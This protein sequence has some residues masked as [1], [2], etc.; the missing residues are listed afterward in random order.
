MSEPELTEV[1]EQLRNTVGDFF[2][3][4]V[5]PVC[6]EIEQRAD[7]AA[8]MPWDLIRAGS[9]LGLRT[10]A[11]PEEWGGI[12]ADAAIRALL[13]AEMSQIEPGLA[14]CFYSCWRGSQFLYHLATPAQREKFLRPFVEDDT[15]CFSTAFTEPGAGSDNLI[16]SDDPNRG[17]T[18]AATR[19][20]EEW[21][22][23][24]Q[25]QWISLAGFSKCVL[26][27]ARTNREVPVHRGSSLFVVPAD[28]PGVSFP[29]VSQKLGFRLYPV[30]EILLDNVRLP[31]DHL[32][33]GVDGAWG[34]L[35]PLIQ[36]AVDYPATSLGISKAMYAIA[37][38]YARDRFQG[39]RPIIE[40]PTIG[41]RLAEMR[42]NI[43]TMEAHIR[44]TLQAIDGPKPYDPERTWLCKVHCDRATVQVMLG[45]L[46]VTG[47]NGVMSEFPLERYCRDVL[48]SLHSDGTESLNLLRSARGMAEESR[49]AR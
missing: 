25:K 40:H 32:L 31:S 21:V 4:E 3:R 16:P 28:W 44:D 47:G 30:G 1:R 46:E 5:A 24:G 6:R 20:E 7:P 35:M 48:T 11:L 26:V 37:L 10:L 34:S 23:N 27:F 45:A 49:A 29:R 14:K 22:L 18:L 13:L 41:T 39:G 38:D 36:E 12:S 19:D 9:Q 17:L 15:F 8:R 33:G 42:M 43:H 2:A